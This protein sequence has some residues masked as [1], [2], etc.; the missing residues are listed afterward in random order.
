MKSTWKRQ[1]SHPINGTNNGAIIRNCWYADTRC[2]SRLRNIRRVISIIF[3]TA[4]SF[5]HSRQSVSSKDPVV[6]DLRLAD[7]SNG[8]KFQYVPHIH[9][10]YLQASF[11]HRPAYS[12]YVLTTRSDFDIEELV[13]RGDN[14]KISSWLNVTFASIHEHITVRKKENKLDYT[15]LTYQRTRETIWTIVCRSKLRRK[16]TVLRVI[17]RRNT[18]DVMTYVWGKKTCDLYV[19]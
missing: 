9:P 15:S 13:I 6:N 17:S 1:L 14:I 2:A 11:K 12:N 16:R 5:L 7:A 8:Y 10:K 4:Y 18:V 19:S 3:F